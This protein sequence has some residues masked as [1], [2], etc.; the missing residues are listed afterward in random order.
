MHLHVDLAGGAQ[1]RRSRESG[2]ER[3]AER[4]G[5]ETESNRLQAEF[6]DVNRQ[7]A[8]ERFK[9]AYALISL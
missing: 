3:V 5:R 2:R 9:A 6:A 7:N 8:E 1:R 4:G